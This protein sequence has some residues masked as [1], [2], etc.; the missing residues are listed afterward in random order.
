RRMLV[1]GAICTISA[2]TIGAGPLLL[3]YVFDF[4]YNPLAMFILVRSIP[5]GTVT[6]ESLSFGFLPL[7]AY[8]AINGVFEHFGPHALVWPKYIF[9]S[10]IGVQFERTRG[11]FASAEALGSALIVTFLFYGLC[12]ARVRPTTR[13]MSYLILLVTP[14]VIYTTNQRSAW[15]AFG[16]CLGVLAVA[17]S[18]MRRVAR[19]ILVLAVL[20]FLSGAASHFS[21]WADSTLFSQRQQTVDYRFVNYATA[22]AMGT[23]NPMFGVGFGNFRNVWPQYFQ[24]VVGAEVP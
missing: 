15:L 5:P 4:I 20:G 6:L 23:A 2:L 10:Q 16:L 18:E 11:S 8:L 1:F 14:A 13:F 7:G 9:D 17:R 21:F 12:L 3:Y 24:P 19:I 22:W